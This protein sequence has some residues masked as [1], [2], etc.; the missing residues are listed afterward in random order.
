MERTCKS[1]RKLKHIDDF[2]KPYLVDNGKGEKTKVRR[3][4]WCRECTNRFQR[5][6]N[7]KRNAARTFTV[8]GVKKNARKLWENY[9]LTEQQYIDM[10]NL[11]G[12]VCAICR[13]NEADVVDH[14]HANGHVRGLLCHHCNIL[15]GAARDNVDTLFLAADY[16]EE[17]GA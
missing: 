11:Q 5:E 1:C 14:C 9:K 15:L 13:E 7:E 10:Y 4:T 16:L 12:G 3:A 17:R 8:G 6:Y 2:P